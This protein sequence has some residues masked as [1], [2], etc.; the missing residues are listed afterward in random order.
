MIR[1]LPKKRRVLKDAA[2]AAI[3][4]R[5]PAEG[6]HPGYELSSLKQRG[7]FRE[8]APLRCATLSGRM[9]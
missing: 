9:L 5:L 3:M 2:E 6:R 4:G 7:S 8:G 1:S